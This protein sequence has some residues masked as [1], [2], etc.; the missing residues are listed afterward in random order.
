MTDSTVRGTCDPRFGP[1][2]DAFQ[3]LHEAGLDQGSACAVYW[4]GE[5]LVDLWAGSRNREGLPWERDT[6]VNIFSV[7]KA[8]TAICVQ[9]AVDMGLLALERPVTYYWPEYGV[10]GKRNT[11][12]QWLLNH[13]AGQPA[14]KTPMPAEALYDWERMT[15]TLAAEQPWWAP[16]TRHG[17]HMISYGW[18]VGEVFRRALGI[19]V[20][21]FL[22][23]E[24]AGPL[25]LDLHLG[26]AD[27]DLPRIARLRPADGPPQAGR[28]GL[29]QHVMDQPQ[30]VTAAALTNPITITTGGNTREWQQAEL[31][32]VNMHATARALAT[33][34]GKISG[35]EGVLSAAARRRCQQEESR[36]PDPVLLTPTRF[37]PG[38]MLQQPGDPEA[39]LGPGAGAFGH[40]GA[41]GALALADPDRHLG[42]AYTMNRMG[43]HVLVDPRP[44]RLLAAVYQ[45]LEAV[46]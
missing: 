18:L 14:L 24:V 11:L 5:L 15:A 40:P 35:D 25:G 31:P 22:R 12:V 45:C 34:F 29:Y 42:F 26:V 32:A 39:E 9:L 8:V 33:L 28:V 38:F 17:Y 6:L 44:R 1:V 3:A 4:Q 43:P 19:S 10:A 20:G 41:G 23:E 13:R 36:G 2:A 21:R 30:S 37:G 16:G 27:S 7:S 46:T